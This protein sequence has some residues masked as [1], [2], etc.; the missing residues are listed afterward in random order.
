MTRRLAA[1][2]IADVAGYGLHSQADEEGARTR[3]QA[4]LREVFEPRITEH[5]GR[6][7]KTMG[8][9]LL[10]EF[11]SVIH[12][13]RCAIEIQRAKA[14]Q[15]AE[16]APDR[17][18]LEFKIGINLGDVIVE[19]DDIHG[20]GVI[21]AERLQQRADKGGLAISGTVYDH[22]KNKIDVGFEFLGEQPVRHIAEPV[23]IYRVLV[24]KAA[25][26]KISGRR[27][28]PV[29]SRYLAA[30]CVVVVLLAV[31]AAAWWHSWEPEGPPSIA[32]LPFDNLSGD[33]EQ[34]YLADGI[35][36]EITTHLALIPGL[37]VIS[38]SAA[39]QFKNADV[40]P[41]Q[42][43]AQ[44]RVRFILEG[45]VRRVGDQLR[46]TAQLIDARTGRHVW[47]ERFDGAWAD[48][49]SFQDKVVMHI[50]DA[51]EL[52]APPMDSAAAGGT[53]VAA[54]YDAYL[55]G[56]EHQR[57]YLS[58]TPE[59]LAMAIPYD[60]QAIALDPDYGLAHAG[61]AEV[62]WWAWGA[63]EPTLGVSSNEARDQLDIH[64]EQ[65]LKY[66]SS[67]AYRLAATI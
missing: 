37:F 46:I 22:V 18:R 6:L 54:A 12:A 36:E 55:R 8:D 48:V 15:G 63:L 33:A 13:L 34:G 16:E 50:A 21:I 32:V 9:G 1:V 27:R 51:I 65:A 29:R 61:L 53:R 7:V 2:M 41:I 45:S 14:R 57:R 31:G 43:G 56:L 24:D 39:S 62:Y 64:L 4:D 38:R 19:G 5:G 40:D 67:K 11:H 30:A 66:P 3:F 25:A 52:R 20:D 28:F 44:L 23:R 42:A 58:E 10:V 59:E 47:A 26:G 49:F 35:T 17:R 60:E